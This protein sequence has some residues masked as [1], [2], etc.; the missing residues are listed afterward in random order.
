MIRKCSN[1][2]VQRAAMI[3]KCSHQKVQEATMMPRCSHHKVQEATMIR[4]CRKSSHGQ[5]GGH[6]TACFHS[7]KLFQRRF[8]SEVECYLPNMHQGNIALDCFKISATLFGDTAHWQPKKE[9]LERQERQPYRH[10]KW[11][12]IS[13]SLP[14]FLLQTPRCVNLRASSCALH[15]ALQEMS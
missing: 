14:D 1:H 5:I 11:V 2:K 3:P 6:D 4:Y 9:G 10:L 12:R 8:I 15:S 13:T 7:S